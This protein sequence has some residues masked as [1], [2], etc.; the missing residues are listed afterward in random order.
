MTYHQLTQEE[1]YL[2]SAHRMA[3]ASQR[4]IARLLHRSPSTVSRELRRNATTHDWRY[5]PSK[6]HRY[7]EARRR[8]CRRGPQFNEQVHRQVE[9]A[10]KLRW[11][12]DQIVGRFRAILLRCS[13]GRPALQSTSARGRRSQFPRES[14]PLNA[15]HARPTAA[16]RARLL[17]CAAMLSLYWAVPSARHNRAG[18]LPGWV[19]AFPSLRPNYSFKRTADVGLR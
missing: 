3:G 10:L 19:R 9:A 11:S 7:A 18:C 1:R 8:R 13:F 4:A 15:L 17:R 5:R 2:I 12:P 16:L 6:A 14:A